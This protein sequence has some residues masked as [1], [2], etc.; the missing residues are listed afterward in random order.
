MRCINI[1]PNIISV[2]F[3]VRFV[4]VST[5]RSIDF[6]IM[7]NTWSFSGRG[8]ETVVHHAWCPGSRAKDSSFWKGFRIEDLGFADS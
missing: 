2:S 8:S 4:N 7:P 6:C 5:K 1:V 3:S